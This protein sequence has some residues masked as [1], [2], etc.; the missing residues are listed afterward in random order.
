MSDGFSEIITAARPILTALAHDN[1]RETFEPLKPAFKA[2]VEGPAKLL[3]DL[4]AEDLSQITGVGHSG[5]LG[6]IYRDVR[7]S[8]DKSPFN[9][10][11]HVYWQAG[12]GGASGWL[13]HIGADR[14]EFMTG[15]HQLSGD[16]LQAYRATV[17]RSGDALQSILEAAPGAG[18]RVMDWEDTFLKRVPK[19]YDAD[20]SH[21]DLLRRKQIILGATLDDA[22]SE[23]G[24]L[25][26][27]NGRAKDLLPFWHW[28]NAAMR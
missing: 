21:A 23:R 17:D 4:F 25:A 16:S 2:G 27:L 18:L 22:N 3:A 11:V 26:A 24:L 8:K 15:L 20:H 1:S 10:Y 19:P 7:F 14:A 12:E 28:C 5:K 13:L 9:T 6:R